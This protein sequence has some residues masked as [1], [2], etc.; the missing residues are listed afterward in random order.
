MLEDLRI[1]IVEVKY[2]P[3][4]STF[5]ST[6]EQLNCNKKQEPVCFYGYTFA[7]SN[8]SGGDD[9]VSAS[10]GLVRVGAEWERNIRRR[11]SEQEDVLANMTARHARHARH[12]N[13]TICQSKSSALN[14]L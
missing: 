1:L 3:R 5:V 4:L 13:C 11:T 9:P 14:I 2:C 12:A 8:A 10:I 6:A 7:T